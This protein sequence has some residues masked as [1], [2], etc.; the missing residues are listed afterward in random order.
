VG[1]LLRDALAQAG[2]AEAEV[3]LI[4]S[5]ALGDGRDLYGVEWRI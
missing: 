2:A 4:S 5:Q 1:G 3:L